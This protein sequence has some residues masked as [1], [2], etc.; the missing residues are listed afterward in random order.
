MVQVCGVTE[1]S[2]V[3][4]DMVA[5]GLAVAGPGLANVALNLSDIDIDVLRNADIDVIDD[6]NVTL[7]NIAN[8]NNV[9]VGAVIQLLG[10]VAGV[11]MRQTQ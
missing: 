1:L 3:E 11:R 8:S 5:G 2:E 6:V 4:L 10:G 7:R 9:G